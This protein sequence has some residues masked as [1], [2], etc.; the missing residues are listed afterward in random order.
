VDQGEITLTVGYAL[1][2]LS[3]AGDSV[4]HLVAQS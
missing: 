1:P 3:T 4:V 2:P